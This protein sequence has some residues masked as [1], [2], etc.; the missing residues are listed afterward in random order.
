VRNSEL[1]FFHDTLV[2]RKKQILSNLKN[3]ENELSGIRDVEVNDEGDSA[4]L[5]TY[6]ILEDAISTQQV[7]ELR[8]IEDALNKMNNKIYGICEMCEENISIARLK[9]KP[10]AK[11][12]IDCR[13]IA[14]K[15][16]GN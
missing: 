3:A 9:V 10:H 11:F 8:E 13:A 2:E 5:S 4:S 6:N 14:E 16:E 7:K 15:S 1:K 12:C